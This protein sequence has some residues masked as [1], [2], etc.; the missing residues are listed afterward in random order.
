MLLRS[1]AS[2]WVPS[3]NVLHSRVLVPWRCGTSLLCSVDPLECIFIALLAVSCWPSRMHIYCS[4]GHLEC[5]FI[6][7]LAVLRWPSRMHIYCSVGFLECNIMVL[8]VLS[9]E[10]TP[11]HFAKS[12]TGCVVH[13]YSYPSVP[14]V[15]TI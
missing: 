7:L 14:Y 9:N 3:S 1:G 2:L 6:A 10:D 5:I 11:G 13:H 12:A 15:G 8:L 4:V